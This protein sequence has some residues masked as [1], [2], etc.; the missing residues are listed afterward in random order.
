[1][2]RSD[3]QKKRGDGET[4]IWENSKHSRCPDTWRFWDNPKPFAFGSQP[5][6]QEA[7][8]HESFSG[9]CLLSS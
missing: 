6:I 1:M 2:P 3:C 4:E 8:D 7:A 9:W 5:Y